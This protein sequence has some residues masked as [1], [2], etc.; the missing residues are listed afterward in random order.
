[1]LLQSYFE[2]S[3]I[4][5]DNHFC[6]T[7]SHFENII[8]I[9]PKSKAGRRKKVDSVLVPQELS[10]EDEIINNVISGIRRKVEAPYAWVKARF[11]ALSQPFYK[12][13]DQYDCLIKF[14][15]ACHRVL[16]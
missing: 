4:V 14:D 11:S 3:I 10:E 8:L 16:I 6:I 5:V 12:D 1:M 7:T 2:H 9:T 15:F 13:A